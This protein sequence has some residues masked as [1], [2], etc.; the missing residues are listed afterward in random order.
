MDIW[1]SSSTSNNA[2]V[3]Y[4]CRMSG[5]CLMLIDDDSGIFTASVIEITVE[6]TVSS[7]LQP[8]SCV[9]NV[10]MCSEEHMHE[11]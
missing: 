4:T 10:V 3:S 8:T 7:P 1:C 9:L 5:V 6:G 2:D 11:F